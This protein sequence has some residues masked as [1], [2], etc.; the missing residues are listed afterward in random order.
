[1]SS[2][3]PYLTM[4]LWLVMFTMLFFTGVSVSAA[5]G[6]D[7]SVEDDKQSEL[8]FDVEGQDLQ[9]DD[10]E[11]FEYAGFEESQEEAETTGFPATYREKEG[12]DKQD[13]QKRH[14]RHHRGRH[15]LHVLHHHHHHHGGSSGAHRGPSSKRPSPQMLI[16][17]LARLEHKLDRVLRKLDIE[18]DRSPRHRGRGKGGCPYCESD[19]GRHGRHDRPGLRQ[20]HRR[21]D[22]DR[23]LRKKRHKQSGTSN[24]DR[25]QAEW[26]V[27]P[28]PE[29]SDI[30]DLLD[31]AF[32]DTEALFD[33][34]DDIPE[35]ADVQ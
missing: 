32:A 17:R 15:R 28:S 25:D 35:F 8:D 21:D 4:R 20:G 30:D 7:A 2:Q 12:D 22:W 34:L 23:P 16:H 31:Q 9:S 33:Q 29:Q 1:M 14:K 5:D 11:V 26:D 6:L 10:V 3:S 18:G 24:P 13:K 27:P 19:R